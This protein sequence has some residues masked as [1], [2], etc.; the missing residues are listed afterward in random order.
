MA[1]PMESAGLADRPLRPP[2]VVAYG[3]RDA[4][5]MAAASDR[6]FFFFF[7]FLF[8]CCSIPR[9]PGCRP[10]WRARLMDGRLWDASTDQL[11]GPGSEI[12][13]PSRLGPRVPWTDLECAGRSG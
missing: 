12:A 5:G 8:I 10:G 1:R 3:I 7:F 6:P 11:M 4:T 9:S 13:N 2:H